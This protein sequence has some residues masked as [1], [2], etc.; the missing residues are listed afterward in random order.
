MLLAAILALFALPAAVEVPSMP[1]PSR[2]GLKVTMDLYFGPDVEGVERPFIVLCHQAG[3]SR[4]EYGEIGRK[5]VKLGYNSVAIDQ[6]SGGAVNGVENETAQW[7]AKQEKGTEFAD[8]QQDI[9]AALEWA[10]SNAHGAPVIAWGTAVSSSRMARRSTW[11]AASRRTRRAIDRKLLHTRSRMKG[12]VMRKFLLSCLAVTVLPLAAMAQPSGWNDPFPPHR[13]MD[14]LYYV[15]TS[16]LSSFLITTDEGHILI[17]SNYESSVPVIQANVEEL[18][19]DFEDIRILISGHAQPR[20]V[21]GTPLCFGST[22]P[23]PPSTTALTSAQ[24]T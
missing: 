24:P 16:M 15:G 6:R 8:A 18:G 3:W 1:I 23:D 17:S 10:R 11:R 9:E 7:A 19:F 20:M 2:D 12:P 22:R 21:K 5:L 14:N 13:V 4:G